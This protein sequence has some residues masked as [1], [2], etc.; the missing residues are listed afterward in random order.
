L[1]EVATS[2]ALRESLN[3]VRKNI[4]SNKSRVGDLERTILDGVTFP[5]VGS[6]EIKGDV[7][8]KEGAASRSKGFQNLPQNQKTKTQLVQLFREFERY[9]NQDGITDADAERIL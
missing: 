4:D 7:L 5:D 3:R 2:N 9:N 6:F 8:T 1:A